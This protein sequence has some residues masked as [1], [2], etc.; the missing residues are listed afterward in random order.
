MRARRIRRLLAPLLGLAALAF[1]ARLFFVREYRVR[2]GS[3]E[4]TIHGAEHEGETLLVVFGS[5]A[6]VERFDLVATRGTGRERALVKRASGLPGESVFLAHGDLFIDG[7][8]LPPDAP[9]PAPV[10]VFDDALLAVED[11]F[12]MGATSGNPWTRT[13]E[14]W[15]LDAR[16]I[17]RGRSAG[18]MFLRHELRDGYLDVYGRYVQGSEIVHDALFGCEAELGDPPATLRFELF[19]MGDAFEVVVEARAS[20]GAVARLTRRSAGEPR[21]ELLG[22]APLAWPVGEWHEVRFSNVDDH[23]RFDFDGRT[24]LSASYDEN[25]PHP[26]ELALGMVR[27]SSL[28]PRVSFGG[29][30]GRARFRRIRV[31]RDLHYTRRGEYAVREPL[32]LGPDELF[33]LGDNSA[34]SRDGRD[35]GPTPVEAVFGEPRWVVWPLEHARRLHG[36][37]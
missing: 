8:L 26:S 37:E 24:V 19:E 20:G 32:Q 9:R 23:L 35:T 16:A 11:W 5:G 34:N 22:V 21:R 36:P 17:P 1:L 29:E 4:P 10:L 15:S 33:L 31:W 27:G 18:M 25:V 7:A 3:M 6:D 2:S 12:S 28:G 13:G 14:A 30:A